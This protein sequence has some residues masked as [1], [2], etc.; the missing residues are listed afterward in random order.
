M[1]GFGVKDADRE[2]FVRLIEAAY[3]D[4][5]LGE[6]DREL[7]VARAGTA[8]T[9]DELE[10]L[11]RD[12]RRPAEPAL[13]ARP[14][15][16][17]GRHAAPPAAR[18]PAH[19][20]RLAGVLVGLGALVLVIGVGVA[21]L[22]LF[23][24]PDREGSS[25]TVDEA[26]GRPG[27]EQPVGSA[28]RFTMTPGDVRRF[29]RSY[30]A[31]FGTLDA[32]QAGL[33]PDRVAVQVRVR[34]SRARMERWTYDGAWRQDAQASAV[35]G[36][37][38]IVDLGA[39]DVRRLFVNI[40][41]ARRTFGWRTASSPTSSCTGGSRTHRASTSTSATASASTAT[42]RPHR[43]ATWSAPTPTSRDASHVSAPVRLR[44][45]AARWAA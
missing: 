19:S 33:F 12:L 34:G 22:L 1:S 25:P 35:T 13:A 20:A 36:P 45:A 17:A 23:A 27:V 14:S 39:V 3:V 30:E 11:T 9:L 24:A 5:Q 40:D 29:L 4:G 2:R 32:Y 42:S 37:G 10:A 41:A 6:Q 8:E 44:Q 38:G 26:E 28:A 31:T 21:A 18:P 15:T 7:R 43:P 16:P